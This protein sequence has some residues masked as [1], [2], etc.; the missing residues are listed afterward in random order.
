MSEA[1]DALA[2]KFR[3]LMEAREERDITEKAA[4]NAEKFYRE[5]EAEL[6]DELEDSPIKGSIK[7]DLGEP[8]GTVTFQPKETYYG[9]VLDTDQ[10]L[11][12]L[13]ARA[14]ADEFTKPKI[15]MARIHELVREK[16]EQRQ[17]LPDGLDFYAKRYIS[18]SRPK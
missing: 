1:A 18:I 15:V 12:Y 16:L 17:P 14:L 4:K 5:V 3:R 6:Y 9:R 10:A 11:D 2:S 7:I 8:Y 13:D